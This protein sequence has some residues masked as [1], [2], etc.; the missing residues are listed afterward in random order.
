MIIDFHTHIFPDE[1]AGRAIGTLL[2][3]IDEVFKPVTDA[4]LSGLLRHMAESGEIGRASCRER[5]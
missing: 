3:N 4:T 2:E 5:V 1:L